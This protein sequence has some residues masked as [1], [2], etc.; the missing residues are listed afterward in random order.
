MK[1]LLIK[2]ESLSFVIGL[3]VHLLVFLL[4]FSQGNKINEEKT[5]KRKP[6]KVKLVKASTNPFVLDKKE[7]QDLKTGQAR[8][9]KEEIKVK[10]KQKKVEELRKF[11]FSMEATVEN[12]SAS[13]SVEGESESWAFGSQK[14][15]VDGDKEKLV[16]D[17][18]DPS[19]IS[20]LP[21]LIYEPSKKEMQQLYPEKAKKE[22]VEANVELK[23]QVESNGLVSKVELVKG[24]SE[25]FDQVALD[26]AKSFR[27]KPAKRD[28]KSV[29]VLI[30]WTYKFR[31][32]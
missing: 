10:P 17:A 32:D 29:V 19:Q 25:E 7:V 13:V 26:L 27:F 4:L 24:A 16:F 11:S 1:G 20:A 31:L 15:K 8:F 22:G 30:P 9:Q 14:G 6:L 2:R 18:A 28:G 3:S 5:P 12:E 21:I 23:I